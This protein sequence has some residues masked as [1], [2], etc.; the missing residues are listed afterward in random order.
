VQREQVLAIVSA[1]GTL[2]G[3]AQGPLAYLRVG[4]KTLL[5]H[6]LERVFKCAATVAVVV[7]EAGAD[8]ARGIL[9]DSVSLCVADRFT[10]GAVLPKLESTNAPL[11]L[12]HEV[13]YPFAWPK[14][15]MNVLV[16]AL[17]RGAAVTVTR[18]A[19]PVGEIDDQEVL[20]LTGSGANALV[21]V[22]QGY[23][24]ETLL[25]LAGTA[26]GR[27]APL[28][29]AWR[30]VHEQGDT[31]CAVANVAINIRVGTALDYEIAKKVIWPQIQ[32]RQETKAR[33]TDGG[34]EKP[35]QGG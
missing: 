1:L 35:E 14:L 30:S 7:P 34:R 33:A 18:P 3:G 4:T 16:G 22:P 17:D 28:D 21:H 19:S 27:E 29:Q 9:G 24:G 2:E 20:P 13:S 32:K 5:E 10:L 23:L 31:I 8:A 25:E 11:V 6:A 12:V 15:M 26:A